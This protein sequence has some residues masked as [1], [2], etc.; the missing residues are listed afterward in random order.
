M[1]HWRRFP[2]NFLPSTQAG[3]LRYPARPDTK[4]G[5]P[6]PPPPRQSRVSGASERIAHVLE[7][8]QGLDVGVAN[9]KAVAG[10]QHVTFAPPFDVALHLVARVEAAAFSEAGGK[11][12][13]H[14]GVISPVPRFQVER[15]AADHVTDGSERAWWLE[16]ERGANGVANGQ[17]Q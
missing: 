2:V 17:A 7:S 5:A 3:T 10:A 11:A 9:A 8:A 15:P 14:R 4:W 13:R 16:F 12:Q 1:T 6:P